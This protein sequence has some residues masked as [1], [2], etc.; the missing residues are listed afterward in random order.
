M[1]ALDFP[2]ATIEVGRSGDPAADAVALSGIERFLERDEVVRGVGAPLVQVLAMS[3]R[4]ELRPGVRLAVAEGPQEGA[5]FTLH[6]ELDRHNFE[7][8]DAGTPLGWCRDGTC[9]LVL[10]DAQ[11]EDRS[12]EYFTVD[13]GR[14]RA[15]R[16]LVPIMI[17]TDP[18]IA[19]LDCLFYVVEEAGR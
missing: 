16:P 11:G 5:D 18:K 19:T 13:A 7:R 4:A 6:A 3:M 2:C 9:P 10:R 15:R 8:V 17:T 1:E 12:A 14:L